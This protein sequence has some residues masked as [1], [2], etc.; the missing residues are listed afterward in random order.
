MSLVSGDYDEDDVDVSDPIDEKETN[1]NKRKSSEPMAP[2]EKKA[3]PLD[4]DDY[5]PPLPDTFSSVR[6]P[7][8]SITTS[9]SLPHKAKSENVEMTERKRS[10]LVPP[11][12]WKKQ[13]N[14]S[15]EDT[16]SWTSDRLRKSRKPPT[17]VA[18]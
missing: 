3:K 1:K 6:V 18:D 5:L 7:K 11:Q 14:I 10:F 8:I 16:R 9:P 2:L 15:T 17:Q 4:D 13:S 12:V